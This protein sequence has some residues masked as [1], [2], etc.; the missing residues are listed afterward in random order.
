[1]CFVK[2]PILR[3][4]NLLSARKLELRTP[5]SLH[6]DVCLVL[7][8]SDGQQDLANVHAGNG[9]VRFFRKH[10]ACPSVRSHTD[11]RTVHSVSMCRLTDFFISIPSYVLQSLLERSALPLAINTKSRRTRDQPLPCDFVQFSHPDSTKI[12]TDTSRRN[13][14]SNTG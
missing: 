5:Q 7:L 2:P 8:G 6:R 11:N 4:E 13:K 1:M 14:S 3:S 9:A 10:R 12:L